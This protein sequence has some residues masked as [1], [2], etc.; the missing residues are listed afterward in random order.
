[1]L[2]HITKGSF[3]T[4]EV[5]KFMV[6]LIFF[7]RRQKTERDRIHSRIRAKVFGCPLSDRFMRWGGDQGVASAPLPRV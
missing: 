4:N 7:S 6:K 2:P 3:Y 5:L 1:M